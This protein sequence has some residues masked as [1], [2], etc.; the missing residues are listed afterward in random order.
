MDVFDSAMWS[1]MYTFGWYMA[2][3]YG[4]CRGVKFFVMRMVSTASSAIIDSSK[5]YYIPYSRNREVKEGNKTVI[6][7]EERV[8]TIRKPSNTLEWAFVLGF[9]GAIGGAIYAMNRACSSSRQLEAK[10]HVVQVYTKYV[11]M[12]L[13]AVLFPMTCG[14]SSNEI[15]E[16]CTHISNHYRMV[17]GLTGFLGDASSI[18]ED[19]FV[20]DPVLEAPGCFTHEAKLRERPANVD[21]NISRMGVCCYH[22]DCDMENTAT[23]CNEVCGGHHC[24]HSSRCEP[25]ERKCQGKENDVPLIDED[26]DDVLNDGVPSPKGPVVVLNS[27]DIQTILDA[28]IKASQEKFESILVQQEAAKQRVLRGETH[29]GLGYSRDYN[30]PSGV[31]RRLKDRIRGWSLSLYMFAVYMKQRMF[32][33]L[34]K[35]QWWLAG[36][37]SAVALAGLIYMITKPIGDLNK[38]TLLNEGGKKRNVVKKKVKS[39]LKHARSAASTAKPATHDPSG[40]SSNDV[41]QYERHLRREEENKQMSREEADEYER[42]WAESKSKAGVLYKDMDRKQ[43]IEEIKLLKTAWLEK[44]KFDELPQEDKKK[45]R[46]NRAS[47]K[48]LYT[49]L[50]S[51][52]FKNDKRKPEHYVPGS[53]PFT[54]P[55][56]YGCKAYRHEVSISV[57]GF[58]YGNCIYIPRHGLAGAERVTVFQGGK[59]IDLQ[60]KG[61]IITSRPDW[62]QFPLPAGMRAT[63][64]RGFRAPVTGEIATLFWVRTNTPTEIQQ[65]VGL[66]GGVCYLGKDRKLCTYEYGATTEDGACGGIYIA[67]SDGY[68]IGVHGIGA[69]KPTSKPLFYPMTSNWQEIAKDA[70]NQIPNY[71][72]SEDGAYY[73]KIFNVING[74][75]DLTSLNL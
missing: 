25:A 20:P 1:W 59:E 2:A 32:L 38:P 52:K 37:A 44:E 18:F 51:D 17:T 71:K 74:R 23:P 45:L 65:T 8:F 13:F 62:L 43:V 11:R 35:Y 64:V 54:S 36:G 66:I 40:K 31:W 61:V 6:E 73:D 60:G 4:C 9:V 72:P 10:R 48:T 67:A 19:L 29:F 69:D 34:V 33:L 21:P 57:N 46:D 47:L 42:R 24:I 15:V 39:D 53:L 58:A 7:V 28:K 68:V 63:K 56:V 3:I 16:F 49:I 26:D 70:A 5:Y 14:N 75:A 41:A 55:Y 12:G 27:T 30:K 50:H 22:Y